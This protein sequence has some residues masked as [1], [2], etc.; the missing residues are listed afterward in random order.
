MTTKFKLATLAFLALIGL[1]RATTNEL[2]YTQIGSDTKPHERR[3]VLTPSQFL[4]IDVNGQLAV[5]DA[6]TELGLLGAMPNTMAAARAALTGGSGTLN[7]SGY[8]LTLP[9]GC[10]TNSNL[11][12]SIANNKLANSA[13]TIAGTSTSLG[14]SITLDTITGVS[15]NGLIKRTGTNTYAQ[16]VSGTDYDPPGAAAA[17]TTALNAAMADPTSNASWQPL[18][19]TQALE[20]QNHIAVPN[21]DSKLAKLRNGINAFFSVVLFSDSYGPSTGLTDSIAGNRRS[22]LVSLYGFKAVVATA[23]ANVL[24]Y[25]E[26]TGGNFSRPSNRW[27]ITPTGS[28]YV[29][30]P[31]VTTEGNGY[32]GWSTRDP[33]KYPVNRVTVEY[34]RGISATFKI[35]KRASGQAAWTDVT[36]IDQSSGTGHGT[37]VVNLGSYA[38][39]NQ[40]LVQCVA[41]SGTAIIAAAK[42]EDSA[43]TKGM[44]IANLNRGGLDLTGQANTT[45]SSGLATLLGLITPDVV[46]TSFADDDVTTSYPALH[47][48][49]DAAFSGMSWLHIA[50]HEVNPS[51]Y[52]R[53]QQIVSF[54]KANGY[55][56]FDVLSVIPSYAYAVAYDLNLDGH[57]NANGWRVAEKQLWTALGWLD[58]GG[59]VPLTLPTLAADSLVQYGTSLTDLYNAA[60][61]QIPR[62]ITI[63]TANDA[64]IDNA[65]YP[66]STLSS[67][68]PLCIAGWFVFPAASNVFAE[69]FSTHSTSTTSPSAHNL[70]FYLNSGGGAEIKFFAGTTS[71]Y[72]RMLFDATQIAPFRGKPVYVALRRDANNCWTLCFNDRVVLPQ[73]IDFSGAVTAADPSQQISA[74]Y[75]NFGRGQNATGGTMRMGPLAFWSGTDVDP[76]TWWTTGYAPGSPKL[77]WALNENSGSS[78]AD[79]SGNG[80]T[81]TLYAPNA[82]TFPPYVGDNVAID[83]LHQRRQ[84]P[85]SVFT[86]SNGGSGT[87]SFTPPSAG[88]P[89]AVIA[90]GA[91]SGSTERLATGPACLLATTSATNVNRIDWNR[92][93]SICVTGSRETAISSDSLFRFGLGIQNNSTLSISAV[94]V[95]V[96]GTRVWLCVHNGTSYAETDSSFDIAANKVYAY[97]IESLGT[98]TVRL[99]INNVLKATTPGGPTG[100]A[101]YVGDLG[102]ALYLTN[103]ASA[104]NNN[105]TLVPEVLVDTDTL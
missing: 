76:R 90:T 53:N 34:P 39:D 22:S 32:V 81:G 105:F 77:L 19:W 102:L 67:S 33:V 15:T 83:V 71:D 25:G 8:T 100:T 12:G 74:E 10:V 26:S 28:V 6:N 16:A 97:R 64:R 78:V 36:T 49:W 51:D 44:I 40:A 45:P 52:T 38:V 79:S 46:I 30:A 93:I 43:A 27:D 2:I 11:A 88:T 68:T 94:A 50:P 86:A 65:G 9:S 37:Y 60:M 73:S 72:W 70:Q 63:T 5:A 69:L 20:L 23:D 35:Q 92:R 104:A 48:L 61:L 24:I 57:L 7:L 95:E 87:G 41:I 101:V 4:Y 14:G 66:L 103:G 55:Q 18:A 58:G 59:D 17:V 89:N 1:T 29:I 62:G 75:I 21:A 99:Y 54:C 85:T 47:A 56:W 42:L 96:R 80:I 98:G 31:Q 3:V 91:T 84:F 82:W 13:I